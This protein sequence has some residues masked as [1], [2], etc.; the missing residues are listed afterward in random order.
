L[1]PR[2]IAQGYG[3]NCQFAFIY[4]DL[5]QRKFRK[6]HS[7]KAFTNRHDSSIVVI[8]KNNGLFATVFD[9]SGTFIKRVS[10]PPPPGN[11][12]N[13]TESGLPA[14]LSDYLSATY[15]NYV[16]EKAFAAYNNSNVLQGYWAIINAS[17]TKYAIRFDPFGNFISAKTI[18]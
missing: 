16:F 14:N 6:R 11:F 12:Q 18:W 15:P 2:W 10:L 4:S 8:S 5:P 1:R 7:L 17:N 9:N 3:C 13:V